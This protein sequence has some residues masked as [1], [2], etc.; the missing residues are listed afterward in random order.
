[1]LG[2]MEGRYDVVVVGGGPA[3]LGAAL[4]ARDAGAERILVVDREPETGGILLQ[5]I[6]SGFGL[7]YFKE[8]L[9][10]PE[11]AERFLERVIDRDIDVISGSYVSAVGIDSDGD[12]HVR[13][14]REGKGISTVESKAVV[15]AMGCRER[16][17]G[18]VRIPG[19]R[20]SGVLTAG[21]AQKFVN[22]MGMLPGK[23]I[24]ILGSGDIGLIMARRLTLEGC[25][26]VGVFELMPYSNGLTRNVVQCL[27]D[28]GIPL[29]LSTTVAQIHGRDRLEK[30]TVAP[31]G[32]GFAPDLSRAWDVECDT[33]L[34][35]IGLVPENE[36][37]QSLGVELDVVTRGPRVSSSMETSL[38]GIF[39]CGNVLH[40]HDLVDFVTEEALKAGRFAG[41]YA[42]GI[43]RPEDNI[44]LVPGNNVRYCVPHTLA[45]GREHTIYMRAKEPMKPCLIKVGDLMQRKLGFVVPA[46][47]IMFKIKPDVLDRFHG[48]TLR[49]DILPYEKEGQR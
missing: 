31:V 19:T 35:S 39:A 38:P 20:P 7:H 4:G 1:M 21:L 36:L 9:T 28:F 43:R 49:I 42:Q 11:Y 16:T 34:L 46:E 48:D 23:R 33:L 5:C 29:H 47:M 27:E 2:R 12:K 17:R 24:A 3:G 25:E 14:L 26:V 44:T 40:V 15:L 45:P 13:I 41:E 22:M 6:H 8:E 30:I 10:G 37:S 32:P 18:A